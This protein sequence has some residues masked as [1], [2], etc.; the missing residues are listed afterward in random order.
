LGSKLN[1]PESN[2]PPVADVAARLAERLEDIGCDYALGGAI[3]LACWAEPRGTVDVDVSF[4]LPIK[5]P[6]KTVAVLHAIDAEFSES[7]VR[8]SLVE[9]GFCRVQ[10]LGRRLDVF[11]PI[12]AIYA[13][14]RLRRKKMPV[15]DRQVMVWDAE[16]LCVF[17]MMFFRRKDLADV[18]AILRTQGDDLD[19]SWVA[20]QLVEMYGNRNPRVSQWNELVDETRAES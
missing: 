2:P 16:T 3:A 4:Y 8:E 19:L 7:E 12:A 20:G 1:V 14:A 11:L 9:H 18:E 15:G 17:K 13:A 10:F 5:E 6:G